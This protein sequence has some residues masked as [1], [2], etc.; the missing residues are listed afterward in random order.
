MGSTLHF[1]PFKPTPESCP[2]NLTPFISHA[3]SADPSVNCAQRTR[4]SPAELRHTLYRYL[5]QGTASS[6]QRGR[7]LSCTVLLQATYS[8]L[9]LGTCMAA[10]EY[11]ER[12]LTWWPVSCIDCITIHPREGSYAEEIAL[13]LRCRSCTHNL[14]E[15]LRERPIDT[16]ILEMTRLDRLPIRD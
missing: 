3:A 6:P 8:R 5:P 2:S 9:S 7:A 1:S 16:A 10:R 12:G 11:S 15:T 4:R 14:E 13:A